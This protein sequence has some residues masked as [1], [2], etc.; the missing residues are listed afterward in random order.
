[1]LERNPFQSCCLLDLC[2]EW[3]L[4]GSVKELFEGYFCLRLQVRSQG[5]CNGTLQQRSIFFHQTCACTP[6]TCCHIWHQGRPLC[7]QSLLLLLSS[8]IKLLNFSLFIPW[9]LESTCAEAVEVFSTPEWPCSS[10]PLDTQPEPT[11]QLP[12]KDSTVNL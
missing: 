5:C 6:G 2:C 12:T 10:S 4:T 8:A 9:S 7:H 1:M 3:C 11:I